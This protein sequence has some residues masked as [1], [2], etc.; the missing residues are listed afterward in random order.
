MVQVI[1]KEKILV[2]D[3]EES[4]LAMLRLLLAAEGYTVLTAKS[5]EAGLE[6]FREQSPPLSSPT[7]ACLAWMGSTC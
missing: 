1:E 7:F 3:D 4:T 5:G 2:I 6:L